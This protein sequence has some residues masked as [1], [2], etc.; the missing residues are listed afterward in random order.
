MTQRKPLVFERLHKTHDLSS[1]CCGI[2]ILDDYLRHRAGQ[3]SRRNVAFSYVMSF[4][5]ET[6]VY[7]YYTLSTYSVPFESLPSQLSKL[8]RYNHIP[9]ILIGR[10]AVDQS[11]QNQGYGELLLIN[12]LQRIAQSNDFAVMLVIVEPKDEPSTAFYTRFGFLPLKNDPH[13]L[14]LPYKTITKLFL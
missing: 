7:G 6:Q 8:T 13:R 4:E 12:A 10:L 2:D 11:L 14:F 3:E 1:F 9:A 5:S